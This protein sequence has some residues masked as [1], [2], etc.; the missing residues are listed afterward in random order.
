[1]CSALGTMTRMLAR[2]LWASLKLALVFLMWYAS[3]AAAASA[4]AQVLDSRLVAR[5]C[6][7]AAAVADDGLAGVL[8]L[9][10]RI[11]AT[12]ADVA[13]PATPWAARIRDMPA[14]ASPWAQAILAPDGAQAV[15]RRMAWQAITWAATA[16]WR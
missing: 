16:W 13:L 14:E 15:R 2:L 11:T 3:V 4:T 12:T 8:D 10:S 6:A 9:V 7:P 5:S 1:M